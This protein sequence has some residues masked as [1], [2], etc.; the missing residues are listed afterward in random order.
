MYV[1]HKDVGCMDD[2]TKEGCTTQHIH[3]ITYHRDLVPNNIYFGRQQRRVDL[4]LAHVLKKSTL[5]FMRT[6]GP[7]LTALVQSSWSL[8]SNTLGGVGLHHFLSLTLILLPTLS[9]L[10]HGLSSSM[11]LSSKMICFLLSFI[12]F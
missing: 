3:H 8:L 9:F 5:R 7:S 6:L 12:I 10:F 2:F 11:P 4:T 1:N